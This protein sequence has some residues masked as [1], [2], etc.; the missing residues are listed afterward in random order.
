MY[1]Q[2]VAVSIA[3]GTAC[4]V[5]SSGSARVGRVLGARPRLLTPSP[6]R[7]ERSFSLRRDARRVQPLAGVRSAGAWSLVALAGKLVAARSAAQCSSAEHSPRGP[8]LG[9]RSLT[10]CRAGGRLLAGGK[11][12][13]AGKPEPVPAQSFLK[14]SPSV[15]QA[16][17]RLYGTI[18]AGLTDSTLPCRQQRRLRRQSASIIPFAQLDRRVD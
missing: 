15:P 12:G 5:Q 1:S 8:A 6:T 3:Q 14:N 11:A 13:L 2:V 16:F 7:S 18:Q 10:L 17:E 4:D 9:P